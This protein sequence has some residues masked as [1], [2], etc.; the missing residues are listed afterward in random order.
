MKQWRCKLHTIT[1]NSN[2]YRHVRLSWSVRE[3]EFLKDAPE[4]NEAQNWN[5]DW[6]K[7]E[8]TLGT[9]RFM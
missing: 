3:I 6:T 2:I 1:V 5:E 7:D 9:E 4:T 8:Q